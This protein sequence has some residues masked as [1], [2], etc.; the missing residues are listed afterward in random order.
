MT[1]VLDKIK[2]PD[3]KGQ[4]LK[5]QLRVFKPAGAPNLKGITASTKVN[6]ICARLCESIYLYKTGQWKPLN[7]EATKSES[8]EEFD[9][10]DDGGLDDDGNES[11]GDDN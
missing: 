5:D 2:I 7:N 1:L 10:P 3:L 8:G 11:W 6:D 4:H 9:I